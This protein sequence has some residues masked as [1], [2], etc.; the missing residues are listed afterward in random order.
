MTAVALA[1]LL[2]LGFSASVGAEETVYCKRVDGIAY[3]RTSDSAACYGEDDKSIAKAEYEWWLNNTSE[4]AEAAFQAH[5]YATAKNLYYDLYNSGG[6]PQARAAHMLSVLLYQPF[7][8]IEQD[9]SKAYE[10]H[11]LA[12]RKNDKLAQENEQEFKKKAFKTADIYEDL[13]EIGMRDDE[14]A[15]KAME[16]CFLYSR[17]WGVEINFAEARRWCIE[18]GKKGHPDADKFSMFVDNAYDVQKVSGLPFCRNHFMTPQEI[19]ELV[20]S[21]KAETELH[22]CLVAKNAYNWEVSEYRN[23]DKNGIHTSLGM[24]NDGCLMA[25]YGNY[26]DNSTFVGSM[27]VCNIPNS[28][29]GEY[30][31]RGTFK[32]GH[33]EFTGRLIGPDGVMKTGLFSFLYGVDDEFSLDTSELWNEEL[34]WCVKDGPGSRQTHGKY[35]GGSALWL[36]LS[37]QDKKF[38]CALRLGSLSLQE[39]WDSE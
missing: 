29:P 1:T 6:G 13:G 28:Q 11:Q 9:R 34:E 35:T 24:H 18:A 21:G 27:I 15:E 20:D 37:E 5:D 3:V 16:L 25:E 33:L 39:L 22:N 31:L 19:N 7:P 38:Q 23:G 30:Y 2:G 10:L 17:G 36:G 14:L 26:V 4:R 8:G 32:L 12:L